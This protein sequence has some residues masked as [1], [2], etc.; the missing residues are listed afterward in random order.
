MNETAPLA[1]R[2][3]RKRRMIALALIILLAGLIIAWEAGKAWASMARAIA[4]SE[5]PGLALDCALTA[6]RRH[7][8]LEA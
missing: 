7:D 1:N 5:S 6:R 2:P 3:G 4:R 8:T